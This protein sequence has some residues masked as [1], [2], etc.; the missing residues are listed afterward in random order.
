MHI[1]QRLINSTEISKK[2]Y[3]TIPV[4]FE[5]K[6]LGIFQEE[7]LKALG[8]PAIPDTTPVILIFQKSN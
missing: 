2:L 8:I 7:G 1:V 5:P 6:Q 4:V 3:P